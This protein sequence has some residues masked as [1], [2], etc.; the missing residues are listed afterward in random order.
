[1]NASLPPPIRPM[2]VLIS[3]VG[4]AGDV[5][6]FLAIATALKRRG[7]AVELL[8]S[9]YFKA[10]IE[11]AGVPFVPIGTSTDYERGVADPQIWHGLRGFSAM[12]RAMK[13]TL[14]DAYEQLIARA[15]PDSVLVGSSLAWSSR[16][17]QETLLLRG[18][19]VHLAPSLMFSALD[20]AVFPGFP[21]LR[22][23]PAWCVRSIL[24]VSDRWLLDGAVA[25]DLNAFRAQVGLGPVR[26]VVS[27]WQNSPDL[28]INAFPSWFAAPQ[29]DWP[30]QSVTA[31]FPRWHAD[32]DRG[33]EPALAAF[34]AA[35]PAPVGITPGS[36]MAHARPWFARSLA[37]CAALGL[38]AVVITPYRDQLPDAL[39]AWVR[40]VRYVPFDRLLPRLRAFVHHGGVGT[41][42]QCLWAGI[43]Q[44]V[45][46]FAHDQFDNA[47]RLE[48]LGVARQLR[49][50]AS[51]RGWRHALTHLDDERL[52]QACAHWS[53]VCRDS[54][55][56]AERIAVQIES[57]R[58]PD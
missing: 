38:R 42:A 16:C 37:A 52:S 56:G 13:P 23:L 4:S 2:H 57:L 18:A 15:T 58:A 17:A 11:A 6:P 55:D 32:D 27:A 43:A 44:I 28:V 7:H 34:L 33:V 45:T 9:P 35:G 5:H 29:S 10:R 14:R 31:D 12:W 47:A 20:P 39:P 8:T 40:H 26:R 25:A 46:P 50:S 22:R 30:A 3:C 24:R 1:M 41:S 19:T 49:H 48:R 51:A 53:R 21:W 36:A 54:T